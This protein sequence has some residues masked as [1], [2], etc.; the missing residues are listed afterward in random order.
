MT[1]LLA[2]PRDVVRFEQ[3][4]QFLD[5]RFR[6]QVLGMP[7]HHLG[8]APEAFDLVRRAIEHRGGRARAMTG[9]VEVVGREEATLDG[10]PY[11]YGA[12][13]RVGR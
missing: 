1:G 4:A 13:A 2:E 11:L 9:Q 7:A 10:G 5:Q 12:P 8:D 6:R 3:L